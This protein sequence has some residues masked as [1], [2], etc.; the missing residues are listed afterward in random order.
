MSHSLPDKR[1]T[2]GG[3]IATATVEKICVPGYSGRIRRGL[4][5]SVN[6]AAYREYGIRHHK[7]GQYELDHLISLELG[8]SNALANLFPE[9]ALPRPGFHEKD[10]L[11]NRLHALVCARQMP[12][13]VAQR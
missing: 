13:A 7:R 12:L 10:R 3:V 5:E 8:G 4:H 1:C 6:V 11:E 2:P 9:P